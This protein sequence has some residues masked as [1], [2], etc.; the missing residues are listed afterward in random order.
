MVVCFLRWFGRTDD[1]EPLDLVKTDDSFDDG[2][3]P[4][5]GAVR[6]YDRS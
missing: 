4:K 1:I 6:D 2:N 5:R 3:C